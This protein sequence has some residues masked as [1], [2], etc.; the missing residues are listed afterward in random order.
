MDFGIGHHQSWVGPTVLRLQRF[1][2]GKGR[3]EG[4]AEGHLSS[5]G[6]AAFALHSGCTCANVDV[7]ETI[8]VVTLIDSSA[9]AVWTVTVPAVSWV[10]ASPITI[11]AVSPSS[12]MLV[13]G[14]GTVNALCVWADAGN[15]RITGHLFLYSVEGP[16]ARLGLM[17][18]AISAFKPIQELFESISTCDGLHVKPM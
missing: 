5:D 1:F 9:E 13:L 10:I 18:R 12:S 3:R 8:A 2:N 6:R 17:G 16:G 7:V 11:A 4:L 14:K 15:T